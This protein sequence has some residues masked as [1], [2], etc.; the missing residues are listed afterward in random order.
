MT[1]VEESTPPQ[2]QTHKPL[3]PSNETDDSRM[4]NSIQ[5]SWEKPP[6]FYAKIGEKIMKGSEDKPA[7]D[8]VIMTGLGMATKIAIGAA[9]ALE[10]NGSATIMKIETSYPTST[11]GR[12]R[13]PKVTITLTK[14]PDAACF[15][16]QPAEEEGK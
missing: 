8:E 12:R 13:V 11:R 3:S 5:V 1:S 14:N 9:A 15:K 7:Y 2:Q 10:T 4:V 6:N 16:E